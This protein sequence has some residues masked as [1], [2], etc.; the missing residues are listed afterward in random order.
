MTPERLSRG[1]RDS[2]QKVSPLGYYCLG[3]T[4]GGEGKDTVKGWEGPRRTLMEGV[5]EDQE[6]SLKGKSL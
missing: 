2:G 3:S 1:N 4:D 5:F 6:Q